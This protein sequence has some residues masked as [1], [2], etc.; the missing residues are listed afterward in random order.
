MRNKIIIPGV[1]VVILAAYAGL[2][3]GFTP[4]KDIFF[5][6][7]LG[8]GIFSVLVNAALTIGLSFKDRASLPMESSLVTLSLVYAVLVYVINLVFRSYIEV[9]LAVFLGL[10]VIFLAVFLAVGLCLYLGKIKVG[11]QEAR[12]AEKRGELQGL[13]HALEKIQTAVTGLPDGT[14]EEAASIMED[15]LNSL[16]YAD[17]SDQ[18]DTAELDASIRETTV[19]LYKE[20]NRLVEMQADELAS[21]QSLANEISRLTADRENRIRM[22]RAGM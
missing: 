6:I 22:S 10:H 3:L 13:L 19:A 9:N 12:T 15:L 11:G 1:Y 16:R 8:V 21:F 7:G 4:T 20:T 14:R 5:W 2:Y 17:F 18:A